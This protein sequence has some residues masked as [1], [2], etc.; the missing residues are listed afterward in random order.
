M[1]KGT[2]VGH[3]KHGGWN[4]KAL[5]LAR[6]SMAFDSPKGTVEKERSGE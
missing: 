3:R 6:E 5:W 2:A 4:V 1:A